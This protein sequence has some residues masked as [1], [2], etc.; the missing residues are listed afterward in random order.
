MAKKARFYE[1]T[2]KNGYKQWT[3]I[4]A[5]P[6][7]EHLIGAMSH[8]HVSVVALKHIG[9]ETVD[10]RPNDGTDAHEFNAKVKGTDTVINEGMLGY[11]Y[12]TL[13]FSLQ[14]K[15]VKEFIQDQR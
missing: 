1:A 13:Q 9:W 10:V 7:E 2:L 14:V 4:Y 12:L 8:P 3:V 11:K 5:A 6:S 15:K